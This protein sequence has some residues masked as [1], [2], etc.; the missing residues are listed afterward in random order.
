MT[1]PSGFDPLQALRYSAPIAALA[2]AVTLMFAWT[3]HDGGYA[4]WMPAVDGQI[5]IRLAGKACLQTLD[6]KTIDL[7][8]FALVGPLSGTMHLAAS[9]GYRA[10]GAG[11]TPVGLRRLF[12]LPADAVT[13]RAI[14][15]GALCAAS[16]LSRLVERVGDP[17]L[18]LRRWN[19]LE[20]FL[21][22]RLDTPRPSDI[23]R[24]TAV[25]RWLKQSVNPSVDA[26]SA[27]LDLSLRQTARL[28]SASHGMSPKRLAMRWRAQAAAEHFA[29]ADPDNPTLA[30]FG[31]SDQSHMIR[32]FRRF[33]GTTPRRFVEDEEVARHIFTGPR[34]AGARL[35]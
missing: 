21:L 4:G 31:F 15:L 8:P 10:I 9:P 24:I 22:P 20:A 28:T 17:A 19:A 7:P 23:D 12:D 34:N 11:L 35:V 6:G 3:L 25:D 26:L 5:V 13:D 2:E 32:D 14:D 30:H 33:V 1:A 27:A 29:L 16:D 18:P